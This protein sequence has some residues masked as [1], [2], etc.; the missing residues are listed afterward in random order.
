MAVFV[1]GCFWHGCEAHAVPPKSNAEWW[2]RKLEQNRAR[3]VRN[4]ES[5]SSLGWLVVRVWEHDDPAIAAEDIT[6]RWRERTG[7]DVIPP[8]SFRRKP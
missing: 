1:D 2:A 8:S 5:L 3:D 6:R 4:A 7:R